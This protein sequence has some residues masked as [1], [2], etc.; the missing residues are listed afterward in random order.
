MGKSLK[1]KQLGIG[2]SQRKDGLYTARFTDKSGKR[3]QKYFKKLQD[4]RNWLADMQFQDEHGSID[5]PEDMSVSAWFEYWVDNIKCSS[6]KRNTLRNYKERFKYNIN[7]CIGHML[8]SQVKPMHCQNVLNQMVSSGYRNS[9]IGLTRITMNAIFGDAVE[10]GLIAHNPVIKTV[11][12]IQGKKS[13]PKEAITI[14]EQKRLLKTAKSSSYYYQYAFVLQ[15]GLRT[16]E[17]TGLKWTDIDLD[18]KCIHISRT[19]DYRNGQWESNP[20]KSKS[21]I[22]D[23]PLTHEAF[24]IL[25]KVKEKRQSLDVVPMQY[26]DLV[27]LSKSGN[28]ILNSAYNM[29][30]KN[31]CKKADISHTT[32][33]ILRHTF[34]TR[35]I[36]AGMTPKTLQSILGHANIGVTMDIYVHVTE[37][38]KAREIADI[39]AML[40]IV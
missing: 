27:F 10:N 34:A 2:I 39:E 35:C 25:M 12:C 18:K 24:N 22:R 16:G 11:R 4:C 6:V 23:I 3:R 37:S 15:T 9:T 38:T 5:V 36:E 17:L 20:P 21:G 19:M 1:G 14:E 40:N 8:L 7:P 29:I 33:H 28:P 13:V 31:I 30:L 26:H 32:M